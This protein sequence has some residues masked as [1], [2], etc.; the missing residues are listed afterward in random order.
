MAKMKDYRVRLYCNFLM[1]NL[2]EVR[3]ASPEEACRIA[4]D[5]DDGNYDDGVPGES[6]VGVLYEGGDEIPVPA[7]FSDDPEKLQQVA[8]LVAAVKGLLQFAPHGSPGSPARIAW[9]NAKAAI[10]KAEG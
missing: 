8:D 3:A 5:E 2:M 6:W 1:D 4:I 10:A 7:K 9:D